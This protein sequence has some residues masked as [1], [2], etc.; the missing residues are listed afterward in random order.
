MDSGA[1]A[2]RNL[3]C[4]G[5]RRR[6]WRERGSLLGCAVV[7]NLW[8]ARTGDAQAG[9]WLARGDLRIG[10][11]FRAVFHPR[12]RDHSSQADM[13]RCESNCVLTNRASSLDLLCDLGVSFAHFAVT[14]FNREDRKEEP[15]GSQGKTLNSSLNSHPFVGDVYLGSRSG[16]GAGVIPLPSP[17]VPAPAQ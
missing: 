16:Q 13:I 4:S 17:A 7:P 14:S 3:V 12:P 1:D 8:N 10:Q 9:G 5:E 6:S 11:V 15:Q 2:A